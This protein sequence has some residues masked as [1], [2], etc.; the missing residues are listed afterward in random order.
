MNSIHEQKRFFSLTKPIRFAINGNVDFDLL[1]MKS[2]DDWMTFLNKR[3]ITMFIHCFIRKRFLDKNLLIQLAFCVLIII[4]KILTVSVYQFR[5]TQIQSTK[6]VI[7]KKDWN[8]FSSIF[9]IKRLIFAV[10]NY[11]YKLFKAL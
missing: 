6:L 4:S 10:T 7:H 9:L 5:S 1:L 2:D 3:F 8:Y 11:M